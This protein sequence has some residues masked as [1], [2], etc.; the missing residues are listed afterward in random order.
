[1][2]RTPEAISEDEIVQQMEHAPP[3]DIAATRA[4]IWQDALI[5]GARSA[6]QN[7]VENKT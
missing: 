4:A 5:P 2:A 6:G 1:M 7:T 3:F